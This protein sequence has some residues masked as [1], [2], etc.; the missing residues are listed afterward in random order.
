MASNKAAVMSHRKRPG[1]SGGT[2]VTAPPPAPAPVSCPEAHPPEA[3]D[4][5]APAPR[6]RSVRYP[7]DPHHHHHHPPHPRDPKPLPRS[8]KAQYTP[9]KAQEVI[10]PSP[11]PDEVEI[12]PSVEES[13]YSNPVEPEEEHRPI[14]PPTPEPEPEEH[15]HIDHH[16]DYNHGAD[17]LDDDSSSE[18]MNNTSED[19]DY[20]DGLAEEDEGVTYYI[21]YCPEDDSYL[22]GMDCNGQGECNHSQPHSHNHNNHNH[23][24][25]DYSSDVQPPHPDECQEAAEAWAEDG[26]GQEGEARGEEEWSGWRKMMQKLGKN[27]E[28]KRQKCKKSGTT[29]IRSRTNGSRA[30]SK[31]KR[32]GGRAGR[33]GRSTGRGTEYKRTGATGTE[34]CAVKWWSKIQMNRFTTDVPTHSGPQHPPSPHAPSPRGSPFREEGRWGRGR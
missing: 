15:R 24:Q 16:P 4:L 14:T 2:S 20:D 21:R 9:P 13:R 19:E 29:G 27:G 26:E 18:Y 3:L 25:E 33:C 28:K 7:K 12:E 1:S 22:E 6:Q 11:P 30:I 32:S 31:C 23:E 17:S 10:H 8:C 34:K 5:R